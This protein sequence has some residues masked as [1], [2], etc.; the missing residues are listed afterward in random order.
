MYK[1]L[2]IICSIIAALCLAGCVFVFVYLGLLWG[3]ICLIAAGLLFCLTLF[4]KNKQEEQE[5]KDNPPP[6][7]GDFITGR[8]T[9]A[10][11]N[12]DETDKDNQN[13]Q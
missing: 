6:P 12:D 1:I 5:A 2:R 10:N 7:V 8:V 9:K 4:F 13:K 11:S 3:L